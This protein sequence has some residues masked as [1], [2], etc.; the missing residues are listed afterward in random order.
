MTRNTPEGKSKKQIKDYLNALG[1]FHRWPVPNG[2]G[3]DQLDC[4]GCNE[5]RYFTVEVK[6]GDGKGK[7]T[8][9]QLAHMRQVEASGGLAILAT[10][11]EEVKQAFFEANL[12]FEETK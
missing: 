10:N 11:A 6:R 9:R 3:G 7:V 5:G 1:V 2:M 8:P 12:L 4:Y